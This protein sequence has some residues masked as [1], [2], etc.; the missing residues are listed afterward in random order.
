[1]NKLM[2]GWES[3]D[4]AGEGLGEVLGSW[5]RTLGYLRTCPPQPG[6]WGLCVRK[7]PPFLSGWEQ[8]PWDT[9]LP[10]SA[11][12]EVSCPCQRTGLDC[13]CLTKSPLYALCL[14][15]TV[16]PER[17]SAFSSH[18]LFSLHFLLALLLLASILK[19]P[20]HSSFFSPSL[21]CWGSVRDGQDGSQDSHPHQAAIRSPRGVF[22]DYIRNLD[23]HP[24]KVPH[25]M[26]TETKRVA[27]MF[28]PHWQQGCSTPIPYHSNSGSQLKQA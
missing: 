26:T 16:S 13:V 21:S 15:F 14:S 10:R 5:R 23:C 25:L 8:S 2:C 6:L 27:W 28:I 7:V 12:R 17:G 19:Y 20:N 9:L 22:R 11:P 3:S 4:E 18:Y 24:A 1:M